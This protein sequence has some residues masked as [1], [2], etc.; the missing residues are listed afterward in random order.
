MWL[1]CFLFLYLAAAFQ[2]CGVSA[3]QCLYLNPNNFPVCGLKALGTL[4]WL[5]DGPFREAKILVCA[6]LGFGGF[7]LGNAS[8]LT[9]WKGKLSSQQGEA[10]QIAESGG[11]EQILLWNASSQSWHR[12]TQHEHRTAMGCD[13]WTANNVVMGLG[14]RCSEICVSTRGRHGE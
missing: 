5:V 4:C 3:W 14:G 12:G 10:C 7:L 13:C 8:L 2:A 11:R 1:L 9:D 6:S